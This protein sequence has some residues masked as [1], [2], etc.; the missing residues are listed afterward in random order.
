MVLVD[1]SVWINYFNGN[2]TWQTEILDQ[3][4]LQIPL[5]T[6]DLILTEVLQ[7]FRKVNE[8]NKA[9]EIMS[10]LSCKQMV[11]YELAIKSAEN[12]RKLRK[13]GVT[14]RKT[15]DVIK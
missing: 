10:I 5:F 2:T 7:G 9:K 3:M 15:I 11:G 4:L 13:K 14:V 8:Y 12:Y 1:S 6:G